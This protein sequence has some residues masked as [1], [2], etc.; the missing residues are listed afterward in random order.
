VCGLVALCALG[1]AASA[2]AAGHRPQRQ[3][4]VTTSVTGPLT[5]A[6]TGDPADGCAAAGQC[7]VRGS[8]EM[9][10]GDEEDSSTGGPPDLE[11][12]DDSAVARVQ[13]TAPDGSATTCADLIGASFSLAVRHMPGGLRAVIDPLSAALGSGRCS[14][15]TSAD[16][17]RLMFPARRDAHGYD[18][19]GETSLTAGPFAVT[20]ISGMQANI[21]FGTTNGSGESEIISGT[22]TLGPAPRQELAETAAVT[23]RVSGFTGT[24]TTDFAG[25]QAPVCDTLGAC[26]AQGRLVQSFAAHGRVTF[27]GT[28]IVTRRVGRARAL[29]DLRD[30]RLPLDNTLGE[31][32]VRTSTTETISQAGE[33]TCS[34]GNSVVLAGGTEGRSP[35]GVNQLALS[36]T[37][38]G[39]DGE[40]PDPFRTRCPGPSA[41]DIL[42]LNGGSL[43]TATVADR[44][45]GAPRMTVTFRVRRGFGG[46][47]YRGTRRGTVALTLTRVRST[48]N[49]QRV[50][51]FG[52]EPALP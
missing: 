52:G 36:W 3:R 30:G 31:L 7:G 40:P 23:Y 44:E 9:Q 10:F 28:R 8:L 26:G 37:P 22:T 42:G 45:L 35:R 50:P 14:G 43:A 38:N 29:D 19:S 13:T 6:W 2:S 11:A 46:P 5:I 1:V 25:P 27:V 20:V 41:Q 18:L 49:T 12:S 33:P 51:V 32:A 48:G 34:S 15:P 16:L 17:A 24:L 21:A 39:F 47:G 4:E